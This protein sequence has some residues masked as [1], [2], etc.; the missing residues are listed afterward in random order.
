MKTQKFYHLTFV[1]SNFSYTFGRNVIEMLI[2]D[3][4]S[5]KVD[6]G[7]LQNPGGVR[8]AEMF[9]R[10]YPSVSRIEIFRADEL[11]GEGAENNFGKYVI[12]KLS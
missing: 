3:R 11:T 6:D 4:F 9:K 10:Q 8:L 1:F 12:L 5:I 7:G 2:R